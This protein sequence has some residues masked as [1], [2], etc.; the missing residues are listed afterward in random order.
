[1]LDLIKDDDLFLFAKVSVIGIG[2]LGIKVINYALENDI[3]SITASVIDTNN[4]TLLKSYAPQRVKINNLNSEDTKGKIN[5]LINGKNMIYLVGDIKSKNLIK[6]ISEYINRDDCLTVCLVDEYDDE[7]NKLFDTVIAVN[8][9]DLNLMFQAVRGI[10]DLIVLPGGNGGVDFDCFK[11]VL[12]KAGK[13][14]IGYGEASGDDATVEA[15]KQAIKSIKDYLNEAKGILVNIEGADDNLSMIEVCEATSMV[16]KAAHKDN[17]ITWGVYVD[18]KLEDIIKIT[19]I[20]TRFGENQRVLR[21]EYERQFDFIE[22]AIKDKPFILTGTVGARHIKLSW[23]ESEII[24]VYVE[25]HQD[26]LDNQEYLE[27]CGCKYEYWNR[28]RFKQIEVPSLEEIEYIEDDG[29]KC[30]SENQIILYF[31]EKSYNNENEPHDM[32]Y[33]ILINYYFEHDGFKE[34]RIPD[35]Y[36]KYFKVEV[37][38]LKKMYL[39]EERV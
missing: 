10:T 37:E 25:E 30:A 13:G 21:F 11:W 23:K 15:T 38:T 2:E 33:N 9:N 5:E 12:K 35:K 19:I 26:Y 8:A 3:E 17:D 36:K 39:L 18:E 31:L 20:A 22:R 16:D 32:H 28:D 14:V 7:L 4:E 6:K 29:V 1:M 24:E 34:L 27:K